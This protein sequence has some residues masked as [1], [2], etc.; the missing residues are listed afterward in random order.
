MFRAVKKLANGKMLEKLNV[1]EL[2]VIQEDNMKPKKKGK[3]QAR[4][5]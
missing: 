3:M 1:F 2:F 5:C 4:R